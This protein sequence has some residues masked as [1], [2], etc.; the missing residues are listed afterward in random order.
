MQRNSI[1]VSEFDHFVK[2][3]FSKNFYQNGKNIN[4]GIAFCDYFNVHDAD[5]ERQNFASDAIKVIQGKY[6]RRR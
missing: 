3:Y 2:D 4:F 1:S 6:L 5:I